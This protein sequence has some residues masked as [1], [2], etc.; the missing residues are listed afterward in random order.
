MDKMTPREIA[1][2]LGILGDHDREAKKAAE[3]YRDD[4]YKTLLSVA[5]DTYEGNP[6]DLFEFFDTDQITGMRPWGVYHLYHP[7]PRWQEEQPVIRVA[8]Y[9]E[10]EDCGRTYCDDDKEAEHLLDISEIKD[11]LPPIDDADKW[12]D[13]KK[14]LFDFAPRPSLGRA[15]NGIVHGFSSEVSFSR[16]N[17]SKSLKN[18]HCEVFGG[19]SIEGRGFAMVPI[20]DGVAA[21]FQA[22]SRD[23]DNSIQQRVAAINTEFAGFALP[24][25]A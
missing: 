3:S 16:I 2:D 23:L 13:I 19:D 15:L 10:R 18:Y 9:D 14:G 5:D 20:R 7:F 12:A 1:A 17:I 24:V 11:L 4:A 8:V 6:G 22:A 25:T 21:A